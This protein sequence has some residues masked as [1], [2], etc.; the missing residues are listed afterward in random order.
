MTAARVPASFRQE[1]LPGGL[2]P[3]SVLL[4]A[5]SV[6]AIAVLTAITIYGG[7]DVVRV[8]AQLILLVA[9][10]ALAFTD[11]RA[12]V[13]LALL[14]LALGGASGA[15]TRLLGGWSGRQ[16]LDA[17]VMLATI[18][19]LYR[20]WRLTGQLRLG[21][22]GV[23]AL[24]LAA[25]IPLIWMPLGLLN[26][27]VP[28]D[29][30][31]DGNGHL[32]FAF[33][34]VFVALINRGDGPW[35]RRCF[36]G[37]CAA[38]AVFTLLLIAISAPGWVPLHGVLRPMLLADLDMGGAVGYMSNGAFRLY[39]GSGIY[40]Q[41][42]LALATWEILSNP[43]RGWVWVLYAILIVDVIATYT[44]GFWL[45]TALAMGIVLLMSGYGWRR[46]LM[47]V[48]ATIA[49]LAVMSGA[50]QLVG[51]SLPQYVLSRSASLFEQPDQT[52]APGET[53]RPD[54]TASPDASAPEGNPQGGGRTTDEGGQY[55]NLVRATQARVLTGHIA[56]RPI[57]GH[58]FGAIAR[59]YPYAQIFSYELAFLDL[60]YKTGLVGS[61]LF[62]SYPLRL[63]LDALRGR[64]GRLRIAEGLPRGEIAVVLA[65]LVS[66]LAAGA[67]NPYILAAFGLLPIL[68]CVA[69]L[70]PAEQ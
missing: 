10:A 26:G 51:F 56:E 67:T 32:F 64:I 53:P 23:H 39:L 40:L 25:V 66:V 61:I 30:W 19:I 9:F 62:L 20:H 7:P 6:A 16:A 22:Y 14:E 48:A 13:A 36:L 18:W 31:S 42:G 57:L 69:W 17:I 37:V 54:A 68:V 59:D 2:S 1:S 38:N 58:G 27:H 12:A 35:L 47:T 3:L 33:T 49:L 41:V 63:V 46:P 45:G 8:L 11:F 65:I 44:R 29:V 70:Q 52:L 28:R 24:V 34:L 60:A 21:R 5:L 4:A 55:S 43:R 15:W 50:G